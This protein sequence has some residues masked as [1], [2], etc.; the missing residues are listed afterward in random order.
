MKRSLTAVAIPLILG[1]AGCDTSTAPAKAPEAAENA[2]SPA[3]VAPVPAPAVAPAAEPTVMATTATP[4]APAFAAIYPGG[5]I[6]GEPTLATGPAGPGG[7][8][9][10]TTEA[11]PDDVV[12]FY[13]Q[14][15]EAA[16]L[17]PVMSMNQ[18]DARAYGAQAAT[19]ASIQVVASPAEDGAAT[20]VQLSWSAGQ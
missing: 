18:G 20:S 8:V 16:G 13:R 6:E 10:F 11:T 15:A 19:D 9:T 3:L 14:R 12:K 1:S 5:E 2:E 17:A 7:L 4:G